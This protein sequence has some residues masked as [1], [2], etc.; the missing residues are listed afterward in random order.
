M[1]FG[2]WWNSEARLARV[3]EAS[4][5]KKY[6]CAV[7]WQAAF[8]Y[9]GELDADKR[10]DMNLTNEE[11]QALQAIIDRAKQANAP[12]KKSCLDCEWANT[13]V[14]YCLYPLPVNIP[15]ILGFSPASRINRPELGEFCNCWKP[16]DQ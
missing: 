12:K 14:N 3:H 8:K 16:K 10:R 7:G 2:E 6:H 13:S 4:K 11:I 1:N 5:D 15:I 9:G